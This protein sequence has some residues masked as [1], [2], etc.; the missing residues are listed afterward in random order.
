[1]RIAGTVVELRINRSGRDFTPRF[2]VLNA[3]GSLLCTAC[4]ACKLVNV[5]FPSLLWAAY[6]VSVPLAE[7]APAF[8]WMETIKSAI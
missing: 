4:A 7:A 8:I 2:V 1:M 6:S 3:P 5:P